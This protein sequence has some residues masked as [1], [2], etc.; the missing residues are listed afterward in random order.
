M[1]VDL[2]SVLTD[3]D[4]SLYLAAN[5]LMGLSDYEYIELAYLLRKIIRD[6]SYDTE[7]GEIS[8]RGFYIMGTYDC[9]LLVPL[10][11]LISQHPYENKE[12]VKKRLEVTYPSHKKGEEESHEN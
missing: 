4:S 6:C 10:S 7:K 9:E 5:R 11:K 8:L 3:D 12:D 1:I 2:L